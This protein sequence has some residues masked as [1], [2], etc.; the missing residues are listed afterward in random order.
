MERYLGSWKNIYG[1]DCETVGE[2]INIQS[3]RFAMV[4]GEYYTTKCKEIGYSEKMQ[5]CIKDV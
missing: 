3:R 1:F 4:V 2:K 5:K